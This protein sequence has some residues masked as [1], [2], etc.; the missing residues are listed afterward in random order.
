MA[1]TDTTTTMM[2]W[3]TLYLA[4][5]PEVQS[6][7]RS[8]VEAACGTGSTARSGRDPYALGPCRSLAHTHTNFINL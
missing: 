7:L 2:E 5:Y 3:I 8:E 6:T 1:G 4:S